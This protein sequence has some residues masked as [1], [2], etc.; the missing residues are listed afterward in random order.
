MNIGIIIGIAAIIGFII[1]LVWLIVRIVQWDSK[2]PAILCMFVC[3]ALFFTGVMLYEPDNDE[4]KS[5]S[6]TPPRREE[7]QK[8]R[9]QPESNGSVGYDGHIKGEYFDISIVNAKWTDSLETPLYTITPEKEGTKLLF[10]I[11]S[12]KNTA[13]ETYNLGMF[14][15]YVDKQAT[16]PTAVVGEI[17]EAMPFVGAVASGMEMKAYWVLEIPENWEELQLNYFESTGSECKQY[18]V[19]HRED[20]G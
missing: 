7:E 2:W 18:F 6:Q 14:N 10:L 13:D 3:V 15:S 5:S 19:I 4:P 12:A 11:F 16:L 9:E 1:S 17:D 20:I 8:P